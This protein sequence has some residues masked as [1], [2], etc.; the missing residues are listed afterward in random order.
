MD[1]DPCMWFMSEALKMSY[2]EPPSGPCQSTRHHPIPENVCSAL[3]TPPR[4]LCGQRSPG[5]ASLQQV[6]PLEVSRNLQ[7]RCIHT[8][9]MTYTRSLD[10]LWYLVSPSWGRN[11]L[12]SSS[13]WLPPM[14]WLLI[15][16]WILASLLNKA[17]SQSN[18][19]NG[20][21]KDPQRISYSRQG[22]TRREG[23]AAAA[24]LHTGGN[25][26]LARM[27]WGAIDCSVI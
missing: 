5:P 13:V 20:A 8:E 17:A 26:P 1:L 25:L 4:W 15:F 12:I 23:A 11:V 9:C 19:V 10:D 22:P 16:M 24:T 6:H 3:T 7:E 2:E 21:S 27:T 14:G 18:K